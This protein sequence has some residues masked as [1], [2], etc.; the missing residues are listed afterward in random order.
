MQEPS[1]PTSPN[2]SS[3]SASDTVA[4][5]LEAHGINKSFGPVHV[6]HDVDFKVYP[7]RSPR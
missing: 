6:L 3:Q 4:P 5:L 7:G 1:S 2:P